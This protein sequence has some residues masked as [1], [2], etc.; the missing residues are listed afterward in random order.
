MLDNK[1]KITATLRKDLS[2]LTEI[3]KMHVA[4]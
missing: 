2:I 1:K 3:E 4:V